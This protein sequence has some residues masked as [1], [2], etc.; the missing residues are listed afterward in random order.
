MK[1]EHPLISIITVVYNGASEIEATLDSVFNQA[2]PSYE[3]LVIDGG[4]TDGT[5]ELL[6]RYRDRLSICISEPDNGIYDAMNKGISH[7]RGEWIY[8]LNCGDRFT[9][10]YV[11]DSIS[12]HL[13]PAGVPLVIGRVNYCRHGKVLYQLPTSIP[14]DNT[15]RSLFRSHLCHQAMF[16]RRSCLIAVG[17]FTPR[18]PTFSDFFTSYR[19]VQEGGGIERVD[20]TIANFDGVGVSSDSRVAVQLYREAEAMFAALGDPRGRYHYAVGYLR[21]ILYQ[22]RV[23]MIGARCCH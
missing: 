11:L 22:L 12:R 7:A 20:L 4:S 2:C 23:R 15:P 14:P 6:D 5:V 3:A 21:A 13:P 17:R 1:R 16:T 8:F 19:I 18:F 9:D 10:A